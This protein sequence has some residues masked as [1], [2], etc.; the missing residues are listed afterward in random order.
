MRYVV[1][2]TAMVHAS[3]NSASKIVYD[4]PFGTFVYARSIPQT[5]WMELIGAGSRQRRVR[6]AASNA[7]GLKAGK[8]DIIKD[9]D[10]EE[11]F[12]VRGFVR[13]DFLRPYVETPPALANSLVDVP[14]P[15]QELGIEDHRKFVIKPTTAP[16]DAV[17][18]INSLEATIGKEFANSVCGGF[19]VA[20][21]LVVTARHCLQSRTEFS[22]SVLAR[23]GVYVK[24]HAAILAQGKDELPDHPRSFDTRKQYEKR[25]QSEALEFDWALLR[26]SNPNLAVGQPLEFASPTETLSQARGRVLTV[27]FPGDLSDA[28]RLQSKDPVLVAHFC[29]IDPLKTGSKGTGVFQFFV[30]NCPQWYGDSGGPVMIWTGER[31]KVAGI[32]TA[33][34]GR[35][36]GGL[37]DWEISDEANLQIE[38]LLKTEATRLGR[39]DAKTLFDQFNHHLNGGSY[40]YLRD[41]S[42]PSIEALISAISDSRGETVHYNNSYRALFEAMATAGVQDVATWTEP[43]PA[44]PKSLEKTLFAFDPQ[45]GNIIG[46]LIATED[47]A[48][49]RLNAD[50]PREWPSRNL[51][52]EARLL[53]ARECKAEMLDEKYQIKRTLG[54][55]AFD[56]DKITDGIPYGLSTY[57]HLP[58]KLK[59]SLVFRF[60][61]PTETKLLIVGGD[62]LI[63]Q[64]DNSIRW[65]VRDF[66]YLA[67][68][69]QGVV[70]PISPDCDVAEKPIDLPQTWIGET[71]GLYTELDGENPERVAGASTVSARQARCLLNRSPKPVVLAAISGRWGIPGAL[72]VD[73]A[74]TPSGDLHDGLATKLSAF[75][76][77]KAAVK[78][79]P[80]LVYCQHD[81][82]RMSTN[83]VK[84][85]VASGFTNV[86]WLRGGIVDWLVQATPVGPVEPVLSPLVA[87]DLST[88]TKLQPPKAPDEWQR[89]DTLD[90]FLSVELPGATTIGGVRGQDNI[91]TQVVTGKV[92]TDRV[93]VLVYPLGHHE[94]VPSTLLAKCPITSRAK[95]D[96]HQGC[97]DNYIG[98]R[99]DLKLYFLASNRLVKI[100]S[101]RTGAIAQQLKTAAYLRMIS[102]IRTN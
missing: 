12:S 67:E 71:A 65:I 21:D 52:A 70:A 80:V 89:Y 3:P 77:Q 29:D 50:D 85:L 34:T 68:G 75:V 36:V 53:C 47:G 78:N 15:W 39:T 5:G 98:E 97:F 96:E 17:V 1:E 48:F 66:M 18:Q 25:D 24:V 56:S 2:N 101:Q 64:S 84:R 37:P 54:D 86:S 26:L 45:Q 61:E 94:Q 49:R 81:E 38:K 22:V 62:L 28:A 14:Q 4:I 102:S 100:S 95:I 44:A 72:G 16:F 35:G 90:G 11:Y 69:P 92:G 31:Y 99:G 58:E 27:G 46:V 74:A 55:K 43:P 93:T 63:L 20:N 40:L 10:A 82:C 30:A 87:G 41:P 79:P 51:L 13:T 73:W 57:S 88:P 60:P 76:R 7:I 9:G 42:T 32:V 91:V 33:S 8:L 23:D 59:E 83:V 6:P 19:L